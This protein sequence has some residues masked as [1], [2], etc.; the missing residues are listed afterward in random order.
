MFM[1]RKLTQKLV[2]R[3]VQA[4]AGLVPTSFSAKAPLIGPIYF[5]PKAFPIQFP[6]QTSLF[7]Y[8]SCFDQYSGRRFATS[9]GEEPNGEEDKQEGKEDKNWWQSKTTQI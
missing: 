2:C 1:Q 7:K 4:G 5:A 3:C 6:T 8:H 9:N